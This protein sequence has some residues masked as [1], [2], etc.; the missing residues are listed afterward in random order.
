MK[1]LVI[2]LAILSGFSH[3]AFA[4]NSTNRG[5]VLFVGSSM[6]GRF[7]QH[8]A[9]PKLK[10]QNIGKDG[11]GSDGL[12]AN[13]ESVIALNPQKILLEIGIND[14]LM[15]NGLVN[16]KNNYS[17]IIDRIQL[18]LPNCV[19][20]IQTMLPVGDSVENSFDMKNYWRP[21]SEHTSLQSNNQI[22]AFND[23]LQ[24][25]ANERKLKLINFYPR[26]QKKGRLNKKYDSGDG[27]HINE[28][29]YKLWAKLVKPYL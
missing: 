10:T 25:L 14:L 28:K 5:L 8:K 6:T 9:F 27:I 21:D 24:K 18:A 22:P 23:F 7:E 12:L 13:L 19:V 17:Q 26:F 3:Q 11:L 4:Q 20:F 15:G 2:Q 16:L 29:G 1:L